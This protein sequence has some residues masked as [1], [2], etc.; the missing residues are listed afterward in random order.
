MND[1][2]PSGSA[3]LSQ[4]DAVGLLLNQDSADNSDNTPEA[5]VSAPLDNPPD[6][7]IEETVEE[8]TTE[9][10]EAVEADL[11]EE[12]T[13]EEVD[14][15]QEE[16]EIINIDGQEWTMD[17]LR[18]G[19]LRQSDY[20]KK[21]Q[22]LAEQRRSLDKA[23]QEILEQRNR[24]EQGLAEIT[25][26]LTEATANDVDWNALKESDPVSYAVKR[27]EYREKQETLQRAQ[28]E[29]MQINQQKM[30]EHLAYEQQ[31]LLE[32]IPDW[33]DPQVAQKEKTEVVTWAKRYGFSDNELANA[34]DHRAV[35]VLRKAMLYDKLVGNKAV[36]KKVTTAPKMVKS[37]R[38]IT[39]TEVTHKR[40]AELLSKLNKSGSREDAIN[41][42]LAKNRS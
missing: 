9:T 25:K 32:T 29:Q 40:E 26:R 10:E 38:P 35:N 22:D 19:I 36:K 14:N 23:N 4:Q 41:Y 16:A 13:N 8:N 30:Q 12:T 37:G 21:T 3:S 34:S 39:K 42:M 11:Q 5:E 7:P 15:T 31:K 2:N 27:E 33:K 24:Y 6:A 1:T 17:D 28:A 18:G 20:T